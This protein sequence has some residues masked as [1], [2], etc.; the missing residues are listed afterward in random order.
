MHAVQTANASLD[1]AFHG[2]SLADVCALVL[3][4][5]AQ[6]K[7]MS[8]VNAKLSH[9]MAVLKRVKF[10][11]TSERFSPEQ[12]SLL[13]EAIDDGCGGARYRDRTGR[14]VAAGTAREE[15]AQAP[16][17]ARQPAA[18]LGPPRTR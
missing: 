3:R 1:P 18:P 12:A 4:Q 8:A 10:A 16:G 13:H 14:R 11:A 2:M 15:G 9:E 17:A 6:I 5:Q 7:H